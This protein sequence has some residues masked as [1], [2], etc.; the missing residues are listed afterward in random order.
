MSEN[1][2]N[3]KMNVLGLNIDISQVIGEKIVDQY[4]ANL[5]TE[6]ME[7][8]MSYISSDLFDTK[9]EYS[10]ELGEVKKP[11]IKEREK[12]RWGNYTDK[13]IPIGEF[14]KNIFNSRIKEELKKKVEEIIASSDYQKK[15]EDIANEL[16]DY[17]INGY[18]EDMKAR[19][20]ERLIGTVVD[21]VPCYDGE[22]L[23][24]LI[25]RVIDT[26]MIY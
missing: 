6:Q 8:I 25:N 16:V 10:Y 17:S 14:I 24:N 9:S 26:R 13:E 22:S 15:I 21:A 20:R 18:K 7:T 5:S 4:M 23:V 12:D 2:K 3:G 11:I 19:I 1:I